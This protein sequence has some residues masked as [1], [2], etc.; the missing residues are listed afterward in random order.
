LRGWPDHTV[1]PPNTVL[2]GT[3][4]QYKRTGT[5]PTVLKTQKASPHIGRC[6]SCQTTRPCPLPVWRVQRLTIHIPRP[7]LPAITPRPSRRPATTWPPLW[8]QAQAQPRDQRTNSPA[9]RVH[10]RTTSPASTRRPL[11]R[12]FTTPPQVDS[13]QPLPHAAGA[14]N[15]APDR[16]AST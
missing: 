1:H 12:T 2:R 7:R 3:P 13:P 8:I 11:C 5:A 16:F 14:P 4:H 10:R 9:P 15:G 6:R